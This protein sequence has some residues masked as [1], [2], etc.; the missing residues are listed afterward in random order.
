MSAIYVSGL[1]KTYAGKPPVE[2]VRGIDLEGQQGECFGVLGPNGAGKTTTIEILEGLLQP[3]VGDVEIFG[4]KWADQGDA[5]R[6]EIGISLQETQ[7]AD[8]L[9]VLETVTLFRSFYRDGMDPLEAL[10]RVGLQAKKF[11]WVPGEAMDLTTGWDFNKEEDRSRAEDYIDKEE[12]IVLIGSPPCV[13]FS[14]LQSLVEDSPRKAQ[15]L[16]EG[17]Q[18]MQFNVNLYKTQVDAG[19]IFVHETLLMPNPGRSPAY[20]KWQERPEST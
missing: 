2:A 3:T 12:P 19:R 11:G 17:I 9:S 1:K 5:I 6:H 20:G 4:R 8:K 13:A 16:E 15:K 18:H 10:R 14:Q 7:L